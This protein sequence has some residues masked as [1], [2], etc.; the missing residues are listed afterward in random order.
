MS[1]K[2][3]NVQLNRLSGRYEIIEQVG[4]GGMSYVYKAYDTKKKKI[5][6]IK[7]LR[8]ELAIDE[9][10]VNK[11][12]SEAL[13]CIDIKHN[14]VIGAYDVVDEGNMHYIV[15]EYV[16][17]TTLN[18]YIK[19]KGKLTNEETVNIPTYNFTLGKKEYH[20]TMK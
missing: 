11:F 1:K 9:E 17:G 15:M 10:F 3:N 20:E 14:N 18:K 6:A 13:A 8:E 5:V 7:M 19:N 4:V 12:K 16:D 2:D